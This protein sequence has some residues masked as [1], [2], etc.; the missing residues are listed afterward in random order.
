MNKPLRVCYF[1]TYRA[2]Y[3][4]NQMMIAGLRLNGVEVI[5]CHA[6]LWHGIEDRVETTKG[7]WRKPAFGPGDR[8]V[9]PAAVEVPA[10]QGV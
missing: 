3:N 1:G 10:R 4:R 7:G 8:C 2:N 9:C 5:E 6:T